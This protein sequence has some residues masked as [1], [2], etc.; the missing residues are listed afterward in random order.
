M[1]NN[2]IAVYD[3]ETTGLDT[4]KC[5]PIEICCQIYDPITLEMLPDGEFNQL[6]NPPPD[7]IIEP[8]ALEVTKIPIEKIRKAPDIKVVWQEFI[9][10]L[11]RFN[12]EKNKWTS[13]IPAGFNI[14]GY[15]LKICNRMNLLYGDKKEKTILFH[16]IRKLDLMDLVFA[17]FESS[18]DEHL[19]KSF[20]L[21][22]IR[23]YVG[24]GKDG[25]HRAKK[26]VE[27]TAHILIRFLKLH[28]K[29]L[30]SGNIKFKNAFSNELL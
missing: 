15:D 14:I 16:P 19:S 26:D 20:S 4:N 6:C 13:P 25:S 24:I 3:L 7:H 11:K 28:R 18:V 22:S 10:Y 17:W 30:Q 23:A 21:D 2:P 5:F 8:A 9:N 12:R 27:D 29:L 1:N